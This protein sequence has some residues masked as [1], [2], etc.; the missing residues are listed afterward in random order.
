MISI[1]ADPSDPSKLVLSAT[2]VLYVDRILL[3]SLSSEIETAIR[4]A[5]VKELRG[6]RAVKKVIAEAAVSKLLSMLGVHEPVEVETGVR[7]FPP[8]EVPKP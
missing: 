2:V 1:L 5:A 3:S 6:N 8:A 7:T 4:A